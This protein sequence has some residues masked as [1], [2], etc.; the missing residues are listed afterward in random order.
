MLTAV[1]ESM[2]SETAM[3]DRCVTNNP[4]GWAVEAPGGKRV[5]SILSTQHQAK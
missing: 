2:A 4:W 1:V 5:R 3:R